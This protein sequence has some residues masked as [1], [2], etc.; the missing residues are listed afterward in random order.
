MFRLVAL[1][2]VSITVFVLGWK[3]LS[4]SPTFG[5]PEVLASYTEAQSKK[6][7][8]DVVSVH[9][10]ASVIPINS[11][12]RK[13][14]YEAT[15]ELLDTEKPVTVTEKVF[16]TY[17]LIGDSVERVVQMSYCDKQGKLITKY[18]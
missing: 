17:Q 14:T 10:T 9:S 16:I 5:V 8:A 2:I 13:V 12:L 1:S 11:S 7:N 4:A 18:Y 15:Y 3:T 6:L